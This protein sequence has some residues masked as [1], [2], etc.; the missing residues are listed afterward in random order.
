MYGVRSKGSIRGA[1]IHICY[2]PAVALECNPGD[3]VP[4]AQAETLLI[5]TVRLSASQAAAQDVEAI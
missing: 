5:K 4:I 2:I 3:K 1:V